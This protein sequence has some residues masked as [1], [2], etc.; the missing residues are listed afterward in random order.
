MDRAPHL[1]KRLG[2]RCRSLFLRAILATHQ[3]ARRYFWFARAILETPLGARRYIWFVRAIIATLMRPLGYPF[4]RDPSLRRF[5][6]RAATPSAC[7]PS[8]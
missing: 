5:W 7:A 1:P 6:E 2:S 4:S 8:W 3:G